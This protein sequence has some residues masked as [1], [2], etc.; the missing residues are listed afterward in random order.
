MAT[1]NKFR[2]SNSGQLPTWLAVEAYYNDYAAEWWLR[3]GIRCR[4]AD[5]KVLDIPVEVLAAPGRSE[6]IALT[7]RVVLE[8]LHRHV[9]TELAKISLEE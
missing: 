1:P 6:R 3:V 7:K 8:T 4:D 9:V 2:P 5:L